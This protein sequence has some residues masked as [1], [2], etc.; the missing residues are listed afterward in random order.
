M[1]VHRSPTQPT[2]SLRLCAV[3]LLAFAVLAGSATPMLGAMPAK[4]N[5][6]APA[7]ALPPPS[8]EEVAPAVTANA[9][10]SADLLRLLAKGE[11]NVFFSPWSIATAID[12]ARSGASGPTRDALSSGL[13][14]PGLPA[15]DAS[16]AALRRAVAAPLATDS[17]EAKDSFTLVQ[18]NRLWTNRGGMP[19]LE[20]F[21]SGLVANFGA[22][23]ESANFSNKKGTADA[24]NSWVKEQTRGLIPVLLDPG[25]IPDDGLI[26]TNAVYFLGRWRTE[27]WTSS[28]APRPF[29]FADG[30]KTDV[31]TMYQMGSLQH[32]AIPNAQVVALDYR[33]PARAMFILP[34]EGKMD[35]VIAGLDIPTIRSALGYKLVSLWAPKVDIKTR[36]SVA[37]QMKALGMAPAFEDTARFPGMVP[38][39]Q[40]KI[41]DVVHAAAL[42]M[43]EKKTEAAAA[44]GVMVAP[45]S[46]RPDPNPPKPIEVRLERPYLVVITHEPTG[47]VL[48]VGR[49]NDPRR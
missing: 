17:K 13:R 2:S 36:M 43:D 30:T 11:G 14:M 41:A 21:R 33:G 12:M 49:V 3:G 5:K 32:A 46:A 9:T 16:L 10:F 45:T 15:A 7:P 38:D 26:L 8:A 28:T 40:A 4:A 35:Q 29:T 22:D 47:A 48:F 37:G 34:D 42:K 23:Q 6:P 1:L 39:G 44:T 19:V 27:F 24:V 25:Q 18:A 31:P 20:S